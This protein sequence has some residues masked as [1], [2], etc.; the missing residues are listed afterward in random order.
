MTE[1]T[2]KV[3]VIGLQDGWS[4]NALADAFAER[5][6]S[7]VLVEMGEIT[8]DLENGVVRAGEHELSSFDGLVVKKLGRDYSPMILDRIEILSYLALRG[9]RIFSHPLRIRHLINRLSGTVALRG[10]DVPM[11]PT[12]ITEDLAEAVETVRRYGS[13]IVKPMYSTKARGMRVLEARDVDAVSRDLREFRADGNSVFYLQQRLEMPDRDLG[14]VFLGGE[15]VGTYARVS[16]GGSW[17]TTIHSGGRYDSHEP[18]EAS[19]AVARRAQAVFGLDFASVD[20]VETDRGPLVFEVSAFGGFRGLYEGT[21]INAAPALADYVLK[22]LKQPE[23]TH[24][25]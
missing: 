15:Y 12:V 8:A 1:R 25:S 5:L 7:R 6:G 9:V 24:V 23:T 19:L 3:G 14:V 13:A 17:N 22:S 18:N 10:A 16:G 4:S 21:G 11:P 20:V 2:P